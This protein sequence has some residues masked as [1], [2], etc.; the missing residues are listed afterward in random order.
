MSLYEMYEEAERALERIVRERSRSPYS[1]YTG[2]MEEAL[3]EGSEA[4]RGLEERPLGWYA[5]RRLYTG[6]HVELHLLG[7]MASALR[8]RM[9]ELNRIH[10]TGVDY[11]HW[12]LDRAVDR[13]NTFLSG[14]RR[15]VF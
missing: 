7:K 5:V 2:D 6:V 11:F 12:R 14:L 9:H 4:F 10:I 15:Q 3:A 13:A 1:I 8:I